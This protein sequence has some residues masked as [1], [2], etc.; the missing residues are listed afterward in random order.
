MAAI[1]FV[2]PDGARVTVEA[3]PGITVMEAARNHG[4]AGI[5]AQC[6]GQCCCA[7]CHG[8][9]EADWHRR[10]GPAGD[11][12]RGLLDFAW[13]PGETSRLTCQLQVD[14]SMD[15]LVVRVPARQS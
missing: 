10:L 9:L 12:E 11:T 4:V 13:E 7:T 2:Q 5:E 14:E 3:V 6:G 1:T 8:Y 15:G